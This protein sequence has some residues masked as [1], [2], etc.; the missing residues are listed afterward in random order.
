MD[1]NGDVEP[2]G[3]TLPLVKNQLAPAS[4]CRAYPGRGD[5]F[6]PTGEPPVGSR[7]DRGY[8]GRIQGETQVSLRQGTYTYST[9]QTSIQSPRLR[10]SRLL[11]AVWEPEW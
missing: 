10:T 5:G 4:L 3:S 2:G 7:C 6:I 1:L 8:R 9:S 11:W